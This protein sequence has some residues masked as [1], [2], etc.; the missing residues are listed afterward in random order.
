MEFSIHSPSPMDVYQLEQRGFS[1]EHIAGLERLKASY[2]QEMTREAALESNR[3]AFI[4]W[5]YLHGRLHS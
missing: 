5:L 3:L 4:R 1:P 2:R